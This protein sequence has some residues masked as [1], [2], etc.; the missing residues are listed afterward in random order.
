MADKTT[1]T[2]QEFSTTDLGDALSRSC[3]RVSP[4]SINRRGIQRIR[5]LSESKFETLLVDLV[6]KKFR[7]RMA[8]EPECLE[9]TGS[10]ADT[11]T[12]VATEVTA[13]QNKCAAV[14]KAYRRKREARLGALK[15][16]LDELGDTFE[17]LGHTLRQCLDALDE[18]PPSAPSEASGPSA[19]CP[20]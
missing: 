17:G 12:T 8:T 15:Q 18:S 11:R 14:W 2:P 4:E 10:P 1:R 20:A 9:G 16:R 7:E 3:R 5:V 6:E 13:L 19:A